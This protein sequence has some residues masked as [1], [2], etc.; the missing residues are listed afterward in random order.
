MQHSRGSRY[1]LCFIGAAGLAFA[2]IMVGLAI[3]SGDGSPSGDTGV[4]AQANGPA[5]PPDPTDEVINTPEPAEEPFHEPDDEGPEETEGAAV[6]RDRVPVSLP[7]GTDIA[8]PQGQAGYGTL[9]ISNGTDLDAVAKLVDDNGTTRRFVYIAADGETTLEGIGP[10][11][12]VL[13][14]GLG[15]DWDSDSQR[16]LRDRS[17]SEFVD[18]LKFEEVETPT[19]V[20]YAT[21]EVTL[22]PVIGGNAQ[23]NSI[24]EDAFEGTGP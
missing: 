3:Q 23:T 18:P 12:C 1:V 9:K 8:A 2:V 20:E 16:F 19:G 7:S 21:Y 24:D 14:F 4:L 5:V 17:Y 11:T 13:R 22:H 15:V 6:E 10:C